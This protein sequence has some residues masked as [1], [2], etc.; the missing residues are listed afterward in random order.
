ME[1]ATATLLLVDDDAMNR[2]ALSRRLMRKGYHVL[3][4]ESGPRALEIVNAER[5]DAVLLDVMMPGMS[6]IETLC[7]LREVRSVSDLPV[8]MVTAK[9]RSED[10]VEA[11]DHGANDYITKPIDFPIALARIRTQVSSRRAD[12]LTG[13]PNRVLFLER[14]ERMIARSRGDAAP[15]AVFFLDVDR[16]KTVNDTLGHSAGD[17]LLVNL[18]RRLENALRATDTVSR[19]TGE[20]TLARLGGDEFTI[21]LEGVRDDA[22]AT[23]VARRLL[24]A[25]VQPFIIQG[26][27]VFTSVSIG[28][29]LD[30]PRYQQPADL[31][32]D[33]DTAMYRAKALGKGR[34]EVFDS[35]MLEDVERRTQ[36]QADL[37]HALERHEL[38]VYYQP[39]VSLADGQLRGFEALLRWYHPV[40]GVISPTE[41]IPTAEET[42]LIVPIG[43]WVLREACGQLRAWQRDFSRCERLVINVNL[44]PRQVMQPGLVGEVAAILEETGLEAERLKLEIT[45]GVLLEGSEHVI[46]TLTQLRGLGLQLGLDDF[47]MG[48]SALSYLQRFP[49]QTLKIDRSFVQGMQDRGNA[50]IVRAIVS[51]AEGLA[52]EVTAEGIETAE[53]AASLQGL[54]CELGQGFFFNKPLGR[55]AASAVLE[56]RSAPEDDPKL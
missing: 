30:A 29:A 53:Q 31:I 41:F 12:P 13:L 34:C 32:R 49:F 44:S 42:G 3:T 11:L 17:E 50:E 15:F 9:D 2:D 6:G 37:Q 1:H 25:A 18:A 19:F 35:S 33:A 55:D 56:A 36:L 46:D 52:M 26:R 43:R 7:H 47:G 10:V 22:T 23:A 8:I 21:L 54:S 27:E 16:F 24:S 51:M 48:Y 4:A 40:R 45:E 38:R 20:H 39:I 14:V 5:V 28:V